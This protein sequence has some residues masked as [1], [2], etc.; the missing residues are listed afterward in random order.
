M[1]S[2]IEDYAMIGDCQTAALVGK[3]G[4]IDWLCFPR[5]DSPS[6]FAAL[7]G[8]PEN[9]RWQVAPI[10]E[11]KAV[12]RRYV[13]DTLV[14]ET[15]FETD[16]GV[17][18]VIDFMPVRD[19]APDVVRIVEGRRGTVR[20]RS[21]LAIRFD[22]GSVVPWVQ[23]DDGG[24]TA[25]AGPNAL[26]L[27][28]P[29]ETHGEN[30]MTVSEFAV[31]EGDRVPFVLTWHHSYAPDPVPINPEAALGETLSW[32]EEW[33]SLCTY[34]GIE[35]GPRDAV[36][37]HVEGPDL[38]A[39]R[40][41]RRGGHHVPA[42]VPRRSPELGLSLCW[43]R[44]ATF[45]LLSLVNAGYTDEA[46]AWR[47][48]LL[49]AVA[50]DPSKLQIMYGLGGERRLDEYEVP[51]LGGYEGS[52]PVR[53]GNAASTQ[54]QLDVYGEVS[55]A[56]H[57]ARVAGLKAAP[58]GWALET[59][60]L[61]FVEEVW[62][63]PDEGIWEVRGEK[64]HFTHSKVMAWVA[65]DRAIKSAERF[66]LDGPL[67]RWRA[68][69][70]AIHDRVCRDGFDPELNSFVQSF[71]SK[72]LDASLLML[73]IVGFLPPGDPRVRGTVEA[74]EKNLLRDGFVLRYD[75]S[76]SADGLP[77]GEGAFLACTFWLADNY[78]LMGE[79]EKA[80]EVFDRLAALCNDVGLLSE[81]YDPGT[82]RL[83]GNYPQAFSHIGL[84]NTAM[85]LSRPAEGP[86]EQ[87]KQC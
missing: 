22:Y 49:R 30:M 43:L 84:I 26:H 44:D 7:L 42:R 25:V 77:P 62:D 15:E 65:V 11:P 52:R 79:C 61:Q 4:S 5:F 3:N 32:W 75:T 23:K 20:V 8:S 67:D 47:E 16:D 14:L 56:L 12:R 31:N 69:R 59:A 46:R 57:Q 2:P 33:S 37:H 80:R 87:R 34:R 36:A 85:N 54:F 73:P 55:D 86:A 19:V 63:Q 9:G 41:H 66:G 21:E 10:A 13:G 58:A 78:A 17:V 45:T 72:L 18:A 29:A 1:S 6:C 81:E 70:Q 68:L 27:R 35:A 40:R 48:W 24:I 76:K 50:G 83:V 71:G 82:K 60:L 74:I 39:Q 51:W 28:T 64:R 53:V 38:P